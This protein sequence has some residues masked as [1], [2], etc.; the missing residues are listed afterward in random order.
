MARGKKLEKA[1][2]L[3]EMLE[4]ALVPEEEQPYEIPGNWCWV[5]LKSICEFERGITFPA[6][7]KENKETK[8]NI[9]CLR[10]ANIQN[11]LQIE[12]LIYVNK[13]YMKGNDAKLVR[14][15][16][17]IM[18]SANSRELVGKT[19]Y[20]YTL[21]FPMTF[22]GFVLTIR[23]KHVLSK[24]LFYYLR[25]QFLTGKFMG[26]STQ[27]TNIANINTKI[28]GN[29]ALA[30][31]PCPEQIRIV[32]RIEKLFNQL[33]EAKAKIQSVRDGFEGRKAA[34]LYRAF[35]GELTKQ[36]REQNGIG[37]DSWKIHKWGEFLVSI[38]AG[39]NWS[40]LGHPPQDDE[41]GVVKVSAVT[42]GEFNE[43]ESK[44][45]TDERQ[46]NSKTQILE[47]D[48]LFSRANTIQLV[49]NCVIVADI[50]K[51]L[52]LSDKILRF[53]FNESVAP[54]FVL[55]FTRSSFYRRQVEAL[56]SGNQDG[57][58]NISQKNLKLIK[59]PIPTIQ[60]QYKLVEV[61]DSLLNK[62]QKAKALSKTLLT[63]IETLKKSILTQA[64]HGQ[65]GTN[66]PIEK[67]ICSYNLLEIL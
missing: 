54:R 38:E 37:M 46:W 53:Y 27:T 24:Y 11:Y 9:A 20:V 43:L 35:T 50:S 30:L 44:T 58:R 22:G 26:E 8:K 42:W 61:M 19:S 62:E 14:K 31:P 55:Y 49:G 45:C 7:A 33:E 64:F 47:G 12:D 23:A 4:L 66:D 59:F 57:M 65:L 40:A 3:E 41:F 21:P 48:F 18:S 5:K 29:Y 36:W 28:L 10:T 34:I 51:R 52:M 67:N 60:E 15:D 1:L 25:L 6:T 16:D 56:A 39:K 2:P 63:Q 13:E 17:I 32:E